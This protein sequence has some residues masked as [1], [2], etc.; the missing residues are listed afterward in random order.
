MKEKFS[1]AQEW[2]T[3]VQAVPLQP[4][5]TTWSRSP[6]VAMEEPAVHQ[7]MAPEG[8]HSPWGAPAGVGF[9][10]LFSFVFISY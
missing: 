6:H 10:A 4:T 9:K 8:G 5:G 7:W 2:P 3:V 1:A